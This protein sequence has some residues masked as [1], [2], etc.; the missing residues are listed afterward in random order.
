[1]LTIPAHMQKACSFRRTEPLVT[2]SG[3]ISGLKLSQIERHHTRCVCAIDKCID[4]ALG[5]VI[6]QSLDGKH[7]AGLAGDMIQ[8]RQFRARSH[9]TQNAV[10]N[11]AC[12]SQ[13]K[14]DLG[15]DHTGARLFR[16]KIQR[17]STSVVFVICYKK[18]IAR[19]KSQRTQDRVH[20]GSRVRHEDQILRLCSKKAGQFTASM[21]E[22]TFQIANEELHRLPLQPV[23]C[24]S[25]KL[26]HGSRAASEGAV[27]QKSYLWIE[28]PESW[29]AG[30]LGQM[31]MRFSV[32]HV[33]GQAGR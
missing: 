12:C 25:L 29:V 15:Y 19:L 5:Q 1:L 6:H 33:I 30:R 3:V 28:E 8:K 16:H 23:S 11:L 24:F 32:H 20:P 17:V 13:R 4:T 18:F 21:I 14:R 27:V 10:N 9:A 26:E 31:K 2:I 22:Q 7:K